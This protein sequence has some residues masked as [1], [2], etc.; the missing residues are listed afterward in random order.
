MIY[1]ADFSGGHAQ[2]S[3]ADARLVAFSYRTYGPESY[4]QVF[5]HCH[6]EMEKNAVWVLSDFGKP[7]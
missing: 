7:G 1:F 4:A 3:T 5:E 6:E 2:R